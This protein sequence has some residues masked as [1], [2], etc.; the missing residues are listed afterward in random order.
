MRK[1]GGCLTMPICLNCGCST[2]ES[3]LCKKCENSIN[4]KEL[5]QRLL[6]Y[7][8]FDGSETLWDKLSKD[9]LDPNNFINNIF[10]ITDEM[11]TPEKEYFRLICTFRTYGFSTYYNRQWIYEI[12]ERIC[13]NDNL[14]EYEKNDVKAILIEAYDRDFRY[15]EAEEIANELLVNDLNE[16]TSVV[17]AYHFIKTRRYDKASDIITYGMNNF[18][19]KHILSHLETLL[20]DM[21]ERRSGK[22]KEYIPKKPEDKQKYAEFMA[23]LGIKVD[24]P[25]VI[26]RV[27]APTSINKADYPDLPEM[28]D[29]GFRTFV[30]YDVE[31]TGFKPKYDEIIEI[32]AIKVIDGVI[33]EQDE[34]VFQ[35]LAKPLKKKIPQEIEDLTGITNEMVMNADEI[36]EVFEKFADFIGDDILVG[37]NNLNFDDKFLIRAGRYAGKIIKNSSFDLM[38]YAENFKN[39]LGYDGNKPS[40]EELSKILGIPNPRAH[41]ALADAITT[42]Q[43]YLKLLE[44][45]DNKKMS[46]DELLSEDWE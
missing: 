9:Y 35:K 28:R 40:L 21:N 2:N 16:I 17:I 11:E 32:G 20:N 6:E 14:S 15:N 5:C 25:T 43:I 29:A 26:P 27:P 30:A 13:G 12:S 37:F 41:R 3:I 44:N 19:D 22:K 7:Q 24:I 23:G 8:P 31:T 39:K 38:R 36:W 45:D 42:A 1:T 10:L 4:R 46:L 18:I 34:F 33:K